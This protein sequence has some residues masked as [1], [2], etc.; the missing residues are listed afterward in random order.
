V[1]GSI[2]GRN[3]VVA[4]GCELAPVTVVGDGFVVPAGARLTDAR[5]P[6]EMAS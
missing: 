3:C 2:L 6:A 4:E 1:A 5:V